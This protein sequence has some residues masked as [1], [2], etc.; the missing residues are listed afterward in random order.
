MCDDAN[1]P[2]WTKDEIE[3]YL[4]EAFPDPER[5]G[6][7]FVIEALERRSVTM[8]LLYDDRNLRPG[9]TIMG[10]ALM[11]LGDVAAYTIVF[12]C[13]GEIAK[14]SV[15]TSFY[16]DF[17]RKPGAEDMLID[18]NLVKPGRT[19]AVVDFGIRAASSP[20][21]VARGSGTYFVPAPE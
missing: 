10:P 3:V 11:A 20:K 7:K 19:L 9:G 13:Y 12:A 6:R 4:T 5:T 21:L 18:L 16:M 14:N 17:L 8:R 1:A 15:T 2:L